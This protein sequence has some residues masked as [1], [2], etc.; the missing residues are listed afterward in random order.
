MG[1]RP[2]NPPATSRRASGGAKRSNA[3]AKKPKNFHDHPSLHQESRCTDV[4]H[5]RDTGTCCSDP[6]LHFV[7]RTTST[8]LD[9]RKL[10]LRPHALPLPAHIIEHA[11]AYI[12]LDTIASRVLNLFDA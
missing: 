9:N 2:G 5:R 8:T 1:R 11:H 4:P 12:K 6:S 7:Y 3:D 10:A